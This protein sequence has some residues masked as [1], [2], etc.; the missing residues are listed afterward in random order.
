LGRRACGAKS[1]RVFFWSLKGRRARTAQWAQTASFFGCS[2]AARPRCSA[3]SGEERTVPTSSWGCDGGQP[4][5][6]HPGPP[7]TSINGS[8]TGPRGVVTNAKPRIGHQFKMRLGLKRFQCRRCV[9]PS[10]STYFSRRAQTRVTVGPA[11]KAFSV[12]A[13]TAPR[14]LQ[15]YY[16]S[17]RKKRFQQS[18][19]ANTGTTLHQLQ[20]HQELSIR[21]Q[22]VHKPAVGDQNSNLGSASSTAGW[23]CA[24]G[25]GFDCRRCCGRQ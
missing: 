12:E 22:N 14:P 2:Q 3:I 15:A 8:K 25:D 21:G 9:A 4:G 24:W 1:D 6:H 7:R 16:F 20:G 18:G 19:G 5:L 13:Q 23:L 10:I 17:G 11:Q